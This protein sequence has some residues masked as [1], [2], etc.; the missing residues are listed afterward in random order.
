MAV[1]D[2]GATFKFVG[3]R[4]CLDFT[5]TVSGRGSVPGAVER[6][7]AGLIGKERLVGF[8]DLTRWG[9][10]AGVLSAAEAAALERAG[11]AAP[12]K[13]GQVVVR[14]RILR[15]SL[16]RLF[17]SAAGRWTPDAAD[18]AVLNREVKRARSHERLA[19]EGARFRW[20]WDADGPTLDQVIWFVVRSAADLLTSDDLKRVKQCGGE[21]CRWLFLDTSRNRSRRWCDMADCGNVAKVRRFRR[22]H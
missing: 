17:R 10:A 7:D 2:P 19:P 4:V 15:E 14:A 3:G 12:A 1:D 5:N 21:D 22:R 13:A 16:Y 8:G 11:L 18:V 20:N 6:D 9:R